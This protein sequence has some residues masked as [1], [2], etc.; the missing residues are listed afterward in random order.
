MKRT[1]QQNK[2][3]HL[4]LALKAE[5]CRDA[6]VTAQLALSKT[7]ELEMSPEMMKVIWKEVQ[8][9]ML[10]KKSTTELEKVG[11]IE[12]ITDHLNR[13][14]AEKFHLEAIDFPHDEKEIDIMYKEKKIVYPEK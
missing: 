11:E 10:G 2:A 3:L 14:F 5:Q 12:E 7:I 4:W 13:Y 1:N 9:A 6:G 8:K